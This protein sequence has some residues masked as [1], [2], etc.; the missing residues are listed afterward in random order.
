MWHSSLELAKFH[1]QVHLRLGVV[2]VRHLQLLAHGLHYFPHTIVSC[3]IEVNFEAVVL[4][5]E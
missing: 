3:S 2:G 4:G 5:L 1:S